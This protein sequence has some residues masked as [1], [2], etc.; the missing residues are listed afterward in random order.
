MKAAAAAKPK[1]GE[2]PK[3]HRS[4]A[5]VARGAPLEKKKKKMK[6]V[7]LNNGVSA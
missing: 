6:Y 2:K 1:I 3:R 5:P 4:I 7:A